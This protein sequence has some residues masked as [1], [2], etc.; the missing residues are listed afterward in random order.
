MSARLVIHR[1]GPLTTVQDAGRPGALGYGVSASGP[2]DRASWQRAGALL[3]GCGASGLEFTMAGLEFSVED[4][5][6]EIGL[7]GGAFALSV[8]GKPQPWPARLMLA[9]GDRVAITPGPSGNY[10]YMRLAAEIGV[11]PVLDSRATNT[12]VGLGGLNGRS[13]KAGDGLVL[14]PREPHDGAALEVPS[15]DA[16]A[17]DAP[18]R[19]IWGMHADLF[20]N[21]RRA[22]FISRPFKISTRLDRMGVRLEDPQGVFADA[23]LLSL[24][25]DSVVPGDIQIL[26]DGTPI[27]LMRDHQP[28]GGYPRIATVISADLDR[29][30]QMRPGSTVRFSPV[31]VAHAQSVLN[32]GRIR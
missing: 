11:P 31:S 29:F 6:V 22:R 30:A 28:T 20:A 27:V 17:P 15:A 19:V 2:M 13:L 18:I 23:Q 25:S 7:A 5:T 21:E 32:T 10:G 12:I 3:S 26:G 24:I 4:G 14:V 8:N 16:D 1:A 9:S